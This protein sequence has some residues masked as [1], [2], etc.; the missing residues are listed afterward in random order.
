MKKHATHATRGSVPPPRTLRG[1]VPIALCTSIVGFAFW[2][3]VRVDA[4]PDLPGCEIMPP[5]SPLLIKVMLA[6]EF[7]IGFRH[8]LLIDVA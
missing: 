7:D 3:V 6:L 8:E 2:I 4:C 1:G 5:Q